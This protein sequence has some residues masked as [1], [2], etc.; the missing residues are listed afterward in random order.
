ME[1]ILI[2][3]RIILPYKLFAEIKDVRRLVVETPEGYMGILPHRLDC[4][5][6]LVPGLLTYKT[7]DGKDVYVAIDEG[8]LIKAGKEI[9]I[10]VRNAVGGADL[11]NLKTTVE[12][13]FRNLTEEERNIRLS[14]AKLES[15]F[16]RKFMELRREY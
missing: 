2:N 7:E 6:A 1:T 9:S 4:T 13:E 5:A 12:K 11:G 10:S 3:L 14:L 8:I 16:A 15:A